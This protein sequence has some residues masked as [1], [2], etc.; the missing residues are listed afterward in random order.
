MPGS[1]AMSSPP[2]LM[3]PPPLDTVVAHF[4]HAQVVA[5]RMTR[6]SLIVAVILVVVTFLLPEGALA[7]AMRGAVR[8]SVVIWLLTAVL[9]VFALRL[10]SR[11][12]GRMPSG[13]IGSITVD[14]LKTIVSDAERE[15]AG[16][17]QPSVYILNDD[18]PN[19]MAINTLI[20]DL[21]PASN[22]IYLSKGLLEH[23]DKDEIRAVY[24]HELAHFH[25]YM[26]DD[27]RTSLSIV[28]C[29]AF[30]F[31]PIALLPD[32]AWIE[33]GA[34]AATVLAVLY[35]LGST[36]GAHTKRDIEFLCDQFAASRAGHLNMV[37]ALLRIGHGVKGPLAKRKLLAESVKKLAGR[38]VLDWKAIDSNIPDHRLDESEY[39]RLIEALQAQC[40]AVVLESPID[41]ESSSHPSLGRRILFMH[42]N[43]HA[44]RQPL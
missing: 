29:L 11:R 12:L 17:G 3:P 42:E 36:V 2:A 30:A 8:T 6:V 14:E 15:F 23:L 34:V 4:K 40:G 10:R 5:R 38:P 22:A 13:A 35:F 37:N 24:L 28:L 43:A 20:L 27:T 19:A 32:N 26:Y 39:P 21:V 16:R 9:P 44:P 18:I 41:V 1:T 33:W 25:G 31:A 7:Q